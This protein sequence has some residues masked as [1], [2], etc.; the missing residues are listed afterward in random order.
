MTQE[1]IAKRTESIIYYYKLYNK[2]IGTKKLIQREEN[3]LLGKV[4]A[5]LF[6]RKIIIFI[7]SK[8]SILTCV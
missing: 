3:Q 5:E 6:I 4:I 2:I 7:I 8:K 1:N